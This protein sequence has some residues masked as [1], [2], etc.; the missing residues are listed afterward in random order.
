MKTFKPAE[1]WIVVKVEQPKE[2]TE[3]GLFKPASVLDR[4]REIEVDDPPTFT[5]V[6]TPAAM[7]E[8]FGL[9]ES[10][11]GFMYPALGANVLVSNRPG[12]VLRHGK[13][14]MFVHMSAVVGIVEGSNDAPLL[15]LPNN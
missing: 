14:I 7:D 1:G 6:M 8:V 3:G 10:K 2:K 9:D 4:E 5:V 15:L 12:M 11:L 13:E